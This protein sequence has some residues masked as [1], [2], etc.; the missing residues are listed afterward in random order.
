M[1]DTEVTSMTFSSAL[2]RVWHTDGQE[3]YS[4]RQCQ[5]LIR[6]FLINSID[7]WSCLMLC[8]VNEQGSNM[9]WTT[10]AWTY[11]RRWWIDILKA[12]LCVA[13]TLYEVKTGER[14]F[15]FWSSLQIDNYSS[16]KKKRVA[17][18]WRH[19]S[20]EFISISKE[21]TQVRNND[22]ANWHGASIVQGKDLALNTVAIGDS[23]S[24]DEA[25]N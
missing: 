19:F 11:Y 16:E 23:P 25:K 13:R 6:L 4:Y 20:W 17:L 9:K 15:S 2:M 24:R 14:I 21:Q 22:A 7:V 3:R 18:A 10:H 8:E 1:A 5:R 12:R